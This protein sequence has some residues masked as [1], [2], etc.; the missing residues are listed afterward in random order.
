[1]ISG[2][3]SFDEIVQ[4]VKDETGIENMRPL[5]DRI[6][7]FIF[8]AEREIGYGGSIVVKRCVY[9]K[10]QNGFDGKYLKFPEDLIELEGVGKQDTGMFSTH[11]YA[12][13]SGG[14]RFR[15]SQD[16]VVLIYWALYCDGWGNPVTTRNHEEAVIAYIVWKLYAAQ[17]FLNR[18]NNNT[19]IDYREYYEAR[20][21]EARGDDAWPTLEEWNE[22]A[23]LS[24]SDRRAL[25]QYPTA[26]YSYC[27]DGLL[28]DCCNS[29]G[30]DNP[31]DTMK[32]YY[33]QMTN[34][35]D[36]VTAVEQLI[37][38]SYL[39]TKPSTNLSSFQ[40]GFT[41]GYS[42]IGRIAFAIL[43]TDIQ[44]WQ[45]FDTLGNDVTSAF[46]T[47]YN[48]ALQATVYVSKEIYTY[49]TIYFRF[50]SL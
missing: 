48:E 26:A 28:P 9:V 23:L 6:R 22:I 44:D 3:V 46:D 47:F 1:M 10:N 30:G 14:I 18:G 41:V 38:E 34:V 5:Y 12:D 2:L 32:V 42:N 17:R 40:D 20:L 13:I 31:S 43:Q 33:W 49:S 7:R 24:Y 37:S 16:K 50:N 11:A 15:E 25:L 36:D 35:T 45:I 8:R 29:G 19:H 27:D 39:S 4:A 21:L